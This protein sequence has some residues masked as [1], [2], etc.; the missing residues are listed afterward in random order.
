MTLAQTNFAFPYCHC[1]NAPAASSY[2]TQPQVVFT[3]PSTYT[4][5]LGTNPCIQSTNKCCY[6]GIEKFEVSA[7]E[8]QRIAFLNRGGRQSSQAVGSMQKL[9][10]HWTE[11]VTAGTP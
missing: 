6:Q 8:S 11:T 7:C 2:F 1:N 4:F 9:A 10:T 3:P 5:T